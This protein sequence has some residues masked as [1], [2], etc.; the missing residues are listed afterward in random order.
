[1]Q[2]YLKRLWASVS[3]FTE[4]R[5]PLLGKRRDVSVIKDDLEACG[6]GGGGRVVVVFEPT[7]P[8]VEYDLVEHVVYDI[9][10]V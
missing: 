6:Q 2:E 4:E 7:S 9:N 1:M 5:L 3:P 10:C 8:F